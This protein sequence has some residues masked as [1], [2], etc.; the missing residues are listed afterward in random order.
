MQDVYKKYKALGY[1]NRHILRTYINIEG[2]RP[3]SERTYYEY[4][5]TPATRDLKKIEEFEAMQMTIF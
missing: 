1:S 3:I 4:L 2:R 5:A